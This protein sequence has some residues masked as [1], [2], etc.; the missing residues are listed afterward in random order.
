MSIAIAL[1]RKQKVFH[2]F[3]LALAASRGRPY[4]GTG[5]EK[6]GTSTVGPSA[7]GQTLPGKKRRGLVIIYTGDGKGKTTA[8]LGQALRAV[9]QGLRV[10][11]VQFIKAGAAGEH[12]AARR[13]APDLEIHR[14]GRGFVPPLSEGPIEQH[15]EA[16][17]E[18][19]ALVK[20]LLSGGRHDLVIADEILTAIH[21]GLL[22]ADEVLVLLDDRPSEVHLILTG[23]GA[24]ERLIER[25]DLVTEMRLVK[26]PHDSGLEAQPGVEF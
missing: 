4:N 1:P 3:R 18:A 7:G 19:L 2:P 10:A 12:K 17:S 26:H 5:T 20:K 24:P 13:L 23:R 11:M 14:M 22:S 15:R 9:G 25:V 8:A 6:R 21:L 16:A